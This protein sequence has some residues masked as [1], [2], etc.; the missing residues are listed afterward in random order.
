MK[1]KELIEMDGGSAIEWLI[2]NGDEFELTPK[3]A[4]SAACTQLNNG[5]DYL[6]QV[7]PSDIDVSDALEAFGFGRNG[8]N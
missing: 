5:R 2:K 8:L 1:L 4:L 6:M 3:N 7:E